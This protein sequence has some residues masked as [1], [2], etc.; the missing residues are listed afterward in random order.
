MLPGLDCW[1]M[2]TP[3]GFSIQP[4]EA[5]TVLADSDPGWAPASSL[6]ESCTQQGSAGGMRGLTRWQAWGGST[7][8]WAAGV[9]QRGWWRWGIPPAGGGR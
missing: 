7:A 9:P 4:L 3:R 2:D 5:L 8:G 6:D 1:P